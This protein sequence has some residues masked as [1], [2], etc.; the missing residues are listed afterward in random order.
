MAVRKGISIGSSRPP[1][2]R[3]SVY[4]DAHPNHLAYVYTGLC[5]LA[6]D[7]KIEL[8]FVFPWSKMN[9]RAA[10]GDVTLQ[11]TNYIPF[12]TPEEC[13]AACELLMQDENLLETM[14]QTNWEYYASEVVPAQR[15]LSC[16]QIALRTRDVE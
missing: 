7:G 10:Y 14:S 9:G 12:S 6:H 2:I 1:T 8:D 13:V 3:V 4:A 11:A 16:I 5:D 15:V